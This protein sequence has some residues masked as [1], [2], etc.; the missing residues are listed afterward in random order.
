MKKMFGKI[1]Y[2]FKTTKQVRK[3]ANII[4]LI[5]PIAIFYNIFY[6]LCCGLSNK[7]F[8]NVER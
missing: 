5:L 6:W 2:Y 8:K 1:K 3:N 7:V 4:Y